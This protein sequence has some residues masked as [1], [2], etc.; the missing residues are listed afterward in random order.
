MDPLRLGWPGSWMENKVS[1]F[2]AVPGARARVRCLG[3]KLSG[4]AHCQ[5]LTLN[6]L[7]PAVDESTPPKF[8]TLGT[9][10]ASPSPSPI[11]S[12]HRAWAKAQWFPVIHGVFQVYKDILG[13][14]DE[15]PAGMCG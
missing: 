10:P 11:C 4:G 7:G 13:L 1:D 15:D 9:S 6:L 8:C 12:C 5:V 14:V 2:N 3:H